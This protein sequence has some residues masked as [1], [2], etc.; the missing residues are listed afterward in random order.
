MGKTTL[1]AALAVRAVQ[2]G[3]RVAPI[4]RDPMESL[5]AWADRGGR[6]A[7]PHLIDIDSTADA[8]GLAL[9]EPRFPM[10]L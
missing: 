7:N 1:S 4:D 3:K 9:A 5:A 2:Q 10:T 6:R 8:I